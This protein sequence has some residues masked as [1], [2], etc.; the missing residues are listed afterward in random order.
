MACA[1]AGIVIAVIGFSGLGLEFTS[2]LRSLAQ[3][4]LLL[5]LIVTAVAGI[6][7][8][9]G[10]PT[11][12]AYIVQTALLVPALTRLGVVEEAAHLFVFYFA[13]LSVITPPVA[14]SLYAANSLSGAR[15]WPA[16][17][18]ALKLASTGYIVPFMFAFGP[19][20]L[21]IGTPIETATA[22][23]SAIVGVIMLAA[24]LHG[25]L[26]SAAPWWERLLLVAGALVLLH[27]DPMTD[28]IGVAVLA[29]VALRQ[30]LA[31]RAETLA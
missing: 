19:A 3:D 1:C 22:S 14:I 11:T 2:V 17:A 13:I 29:L 30:T 27:P 4:S 23:V 31:R 16:G 12:P 20:L 25:F 8:G 5:A 10:L 26:L 21:L 28:L 9:M 18:A 7:L 6:V 15:L 24:G